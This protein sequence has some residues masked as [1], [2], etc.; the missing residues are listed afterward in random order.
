MTK[1]L[2]QEQTL[3][4][5]YREKKVLT[6]ELVQAKQHILALADVIANQQILVTKLQKVSIWRKLLNKLK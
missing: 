6:D 4:A 5:L 1:T 3:K 2:N